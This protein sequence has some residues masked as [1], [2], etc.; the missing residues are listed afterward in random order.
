AEPVRG[1]NQALLREAGAQ[2]PASPRAAPGLGQHLAP[3]TTGSRRASRASCLLSALFCSPCSSSPPR[4]P[5][6]AQCRAPQWAPGCCSPG[7]WG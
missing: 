4:R 6:T 5:R 1:P 2:S 7:W 3:G